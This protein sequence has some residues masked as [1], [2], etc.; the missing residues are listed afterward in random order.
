MKIRYLITF[1]QIIALSFTLIVYSVVNAEPPLVILKELWPTTKDP[2]E[3]TERVLP[4]R[5]DNVKRVTD[6]TEPSLTVYRVN[7]RENPTPAVL[8][9]PGGAYSYLAIDKEGTEIA[10]WL[11]SIEI[12]AIVVK[13]RVP[14]N[15][16]AAFQDAQRAMRLVRYHA[17][18]WNID[19]K[20][21]GV[22]GFSAGGHL[23][24]RISTDFKKR[25]YT[26]LDDVDMEACRPDFCILIYPAYLI[27]ERTKKL[28]NEL[29][30]MPHTPPTF[31]VQTKDD[32][33]FVAG[34]IAYDQALRK[35][36]VSST[37]Q[38]FPDGGHGYG[39][40]PSKHD[41]SNWPKLCEIWLKENA[42]ISNISSKKDAGDGL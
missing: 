21:V 25:S 13:Y 1:I 9:F 11:N 4:C 36:R 30:V 41:V 24:A 5:G 23:S 19:S 34:T 8:V 2:N 29:P 15:R 33:N 28:A 10:M 18:E 20:R 38:L 7:K 27:N 14:N 32:T 26:S 17:K 42:I 6:I 12:T 16:E 3:L 40:R 22:I 37:F 39:L 31:I 35:A